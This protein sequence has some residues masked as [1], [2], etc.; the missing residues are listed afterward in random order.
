MFNQV[1]KSIPKVKTLREAI[2]ESQ[3][4]PIEFEGMIYLKGVPVIRWAKPKE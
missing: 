4:R 2:E 1:D 3:L